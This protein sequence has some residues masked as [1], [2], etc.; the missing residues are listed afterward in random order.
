MSSA[1]TSRLIRCSKTVQTDMSFHYLTA[2]MIIK[3]VSFLVMMRFWIY[4]IS[5]QV[6]GTDC[7][8]IYCRKSFFNTNTCTLTAVYFS[9]NENF[10]LPIFWAQSELIKK[11]LNDDLE[12]ALLQICFVH[13]IGPFDK[14]LVLC[15][16]HHIEIMRQIFKVL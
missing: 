14:T 10:S 6:K 15:I 1:C 3:Y 16:L 7:F 12:S 2:I 4:S 9:T 11:L 8:Q 5:L 13:V